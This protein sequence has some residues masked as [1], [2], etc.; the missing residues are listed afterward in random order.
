M[1]EKFVVSQKFCRQD[2]RPLLAE[3][4]IAAKSA[5]L[6]AAGDGRKGLR[7]LMP[8]QNDRA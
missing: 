1:V 2:A 3:F 5:R 7:S 6:D 4:D 8:V